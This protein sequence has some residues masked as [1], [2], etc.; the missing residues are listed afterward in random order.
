MDYIRVM[1]QVETCRMVGTLNNVLVA[2]R[3]EVVVSS[4]RLQRFLLIV[5]GLFLSATILPPNSGVHLRHNRTKR[6][7]LVFVRGRNRPAPVERELVNLDRATLRSSGPEIQPRRQ[8]T[9]LIVW[10]IENDELARSRTRSNRRLV[11]RS[12]LSQV[13]LRC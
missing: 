4:R 7:G 10:A 9:S 1:T 13:R 11:G 12:A 2:Y 6:T 3:F 5:A 8:R